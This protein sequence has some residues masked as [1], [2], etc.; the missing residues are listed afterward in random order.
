M[1]VAVYANGHM[2]SSADSSSGG[3]GIVAPTPIR[4]MYN[5]TQ[6]GGG[7]SGAGLPRVSV[8]DILSPPHGTPSSL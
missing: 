3:S 6:P 4:P 5:R 1:F 7:Y 8:G 2:M